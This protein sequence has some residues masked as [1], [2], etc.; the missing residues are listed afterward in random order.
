MNSTH[1]VHQGGSDKP[2]TYNLRCT[3]VLEVAAADNLLNYETAALAVK[4]LGKC[5]LCG[6]GAQGELRLKLKQA[7]RHADA[8]VRRF[9]KERR[10][11]PRMSA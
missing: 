6:K 5:A 11:P 1:V 2:N 9:K 3:S 10:Q 4:H 7:R 8:A